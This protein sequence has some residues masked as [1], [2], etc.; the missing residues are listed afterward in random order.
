MLSLIILVLVVLVIVGS[1]SIWLAREQLEHQVW[2]QLTQGALA[3]HALYEVRQQDLVETA[4]LFVERPTLQILLLA[5]DYAALDEYLETFQGSVSPDSVLVCD[6]DGHMLGCGGDESGCRLLAHQPC[7]PAVALDRQI[8]EGAVWAES[9]ATIWLSV[10]QVVASDQE[11]E[12]LGGV[13]LGMAVDSMFAQQLASQTG[14]EH[15]FF[16]YG[17][18]T[19]TSLAEVPVWENR[20]F[21]QGGIPYY[22]LS[23]NLGGGVTDYLAL[24]V[25]D[26]TTMQR[27]LVRVVTGSGLGTL[28]V[29][30]LLGIYFARWLGRPLTGLSEAAA[31]LQAADATV[32]SQAMSEVLHRGQIREVA[33]VARI[34]ETKQGDLV[35]VHQSL[36]QEK[37]WTKNLLESIVEGIVTLDAGGQIMFFNRGAEHITGWQRVEVL[38]KRFPQVFELAESERSSSAYLPAPGEHCKLAVLL[39]DG[40]PATLAVTR[41][42]LPLG[43]ESRIALVFRDVSTE[44]VIHRMMG[45]FVANLAHEF[46]TPLSGL[47]ASVELLLDQIPYLSLAEI[48]E[49]LNAIHLSVLGLQALINN[50]LE[51]ASIEAGEFRVHVRPVAIAEIITE[52]LHTMHPL[53]VKR[54]QW[55]T[56]D[57]P[58][59]LPAVCADLRRTEQVLV[60]LLSNASKYGPDNAE[61]IIAVT[62]ERE[63]LRVNVT[64]HGKGIPDE[65][66]KILFHRFVRTR[67]AYAQNQVGMGLGL[68]VVKAIVEAEGG[69]V[70]VMDAPSGG[71]TFWFTVPLAQQAAEGKNESIGC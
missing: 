17:E 30:S 7:A 26:L 3:T 14:I 28:A 48:R 38:G 44:E 69:A 43:D 66:K 71:T 2:S 20:K 1:F 4:Q 23:L 9:G 11:A 55:L 56:L 59:S 24:N 54:G 10:Y 16:W 52:T 45:Y 8:T 67:E 18:P 36:R 40:Q 21:S 37:A 25:Q 64:D 63:S 70:G 29:I 27:H 22:A 60:N 42:L 65:Q 50:L 62:L 33:Q 49:L 58:E 51:G 12:P 57:L 32:S 5:E 35:Q 47:A 46:R 31:A 53:L 39:A 13:V 68:S 34:L 6:I 61:I 19:T 41:A 15:T